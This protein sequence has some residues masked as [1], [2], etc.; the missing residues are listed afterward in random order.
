MNKPQ[1]LSWDVLNI[2]LAAEADRIAEKLRDVTA[3]VLKKRGLVVAI[4]A[5][6]EGHHVHVNFIG[7]GHIAAKVNRMAA[8]QIFRLKRWNRDWSSA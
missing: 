1:A 7:L 4:F 8:Q 3:N 5:T 6:D 2:D